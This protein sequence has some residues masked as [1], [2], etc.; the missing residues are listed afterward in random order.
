VYDL[1]LVAVDSKEIG[2]I[3]GALANGF[4]MSDLGEL[5][6]FLGLKIKQDGINQILT[7]SQN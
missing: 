6:T 3:K 4:E 1:V 2:W 5:A 7:L